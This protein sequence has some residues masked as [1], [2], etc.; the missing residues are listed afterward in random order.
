M[1]ETIEIGYQVF[2]S[3]GG[4]EI[5]A[6]RQ[7][8]PQEIVVWIENAGDFAISLDAVEAVRSQ[9]VILVPDKLDAKLLEAIAHAHDAE[10]PHV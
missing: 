10:Q 5:G 4:E 9:K 1:R 6:V 3:G 8:T 2:V 7:V